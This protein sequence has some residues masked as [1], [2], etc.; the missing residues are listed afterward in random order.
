M[1]QAGD[2][3]EPGCGEKLPTS[4]RSGFGTCQ[5]L[6]FVSTLV[7]L[8]PQQVTSEAAW[9]EKIIQHSHPQTRGRGKRRGETW[10]VMV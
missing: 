1:A 8:S 6:G 4:A 9:K 7:T 3:G 5:I 10:L 2:Q